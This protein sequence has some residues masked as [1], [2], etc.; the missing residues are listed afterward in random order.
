MTSSSHYLGLFGDWVCQAKDVRQ[1]A[2]KL[3]EKTFIGC[4]TPEEANII[5]QAVKTEYPDPKQYEARL[6]CLNENTN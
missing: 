2:A 3:C 1:K 4:L 6:Q 5:A